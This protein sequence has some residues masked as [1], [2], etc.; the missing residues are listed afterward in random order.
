MILKQLTTLDLKLKDNFVSKEIF[1][2]WDNYS[3]IDEVME[4]E[5]GDINPAENDAVIDENQEYNEYSQTHTI[6]RDDKEEENE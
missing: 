1:D 4:V 5:D 2:N 3:L 6:N